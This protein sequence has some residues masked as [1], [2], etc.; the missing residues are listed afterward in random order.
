MKQIILCIIVLLLIA[1]C[2]SG[3]KTSHADL[4]KD[5]PEWARRTPNNPS[6]YHGVGMAAKS[7]HQDFRERARQN[8]LSELAAGISV[9]ISSSS[10]LNQLEIDNT[11]SEYFRDNIRMTTMQRLEGYELVD[12]WEN[13][14]QY[15]VYYRLS[16]AKW[17]QVQQERTDKAMRL[18]KSN[19]EQA[20]SFN[21]QS[22][23]TDAMRFYI[24]AVE[25][26]KDF[27]GE[28][29]RADID[30]AE[31]SYSTVLLADLSAT[32]QNLH[33][34]FA[35]DKLMMSPGSSA[36]KHS[37]EGTVT[38]K[39]KSSISGIPVN[40]RYSWR[41]GSVDEAV[42]D[43][44]G[45][46]AIHPP[47][48]NSRSHNPHITC[49]FNLDKMVSDN[50]SDL[51]VR[52]LFDGMKVNSFSLPVQ[53]INPVFYVTVI[54]QNL[55]HEYKGH[56]IEEELSGLLRKDGFR[57]SNSPAG[58]D[59]ILSVEAGTTQA[60]ERNNRFSSQLTATFLVKDG[61]GKII[62]N[63]TET[64]ISG[65]GGSYLQAGEDAYRSLAGKISITIYPD[66]IRNVFN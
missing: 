55:N 34:Q 18:S 60:S 26:I 39:H 28:D 37:V 49:T 48:I 33:I 64:G 4:M 23:H 62:Y 63:K 56:G 61:M 42:S 14:Q 20:R 1:G 27:L 53:L 31:R 8:A 57:I 41:P 45:K 40:I 13:E 43:A 36:G 59:Y 52:K 12:N 66:I 38:D 2:S 17:A 21:N 51:M 19:F 7:V 54:G 25:D 15:W 11:F 47:A 50:T 5:A 10:V 35:V 65:L 58:A 24:R 3:R 6:W 46:F 32:L 16:K 29:I 44:S 22:K 9:T 30:G